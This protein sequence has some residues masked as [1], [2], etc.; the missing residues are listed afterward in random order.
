MGSLQSLTT[1][2]ERTSLLGARAP[3]LTSL[4]AA[5]PLIPRLLA[6][7]PVAEG[8]PLAIPRA[9]L[10]HA[11]EYR[12][13]RFRHCR[14]LPLSLLSYAAFIATLL[15][16]AKVSIAYDLQAAAAAAFVA[17]SGFSEL[18]ASAAGWYGWVAQGFL[19]LLLPAALNG[20]AGSDWAARPL[21]GYTVLVG[22]ARL[23]QARSVAVECTEDAGLRALYSTP[24]YPSTQLS[25]APFGAPLLGANVSAAFAPGPGRGAEGL[26]RIPYAFELIL[27]AQNTSL[28]KGVGIIEEL[29][30]GGWLDAAT[31][32]V[33]A[34]AVLYNGQIATWATVRCTMDVQRGGRLS[35]S[36]KVDVFPAD[37]Y[38]TPPDTLAEAS[39]GS[40]GSDGTDV[41]GELLVFLDLVVLLYFLYLSRGTAH[42]VW[43]VFTEKGRRAPHT[44][45]ARLPAACGY[46]LVLDYAS[47]CTLFAMGV[48]WA[49]FVARAGALRGEFAGV[50]APSPTTFSSAAFAG[51]ATR[52][53][54][55]QEAW[56]NFKVAATLALICL[57][58]RLFKYFKFQPRLAVMTDSLSMA[59]TDGAHFAFLFAVMLGAWRCK[60]HPPPPFQNPLTPPPPLP[61]PPQCATARGAASCL[62]TRPWTG[63]TR[64]SAS[65]RCSAT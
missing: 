24:C 8:A 32:S 63:P 5:P 6:S 58:L 11:L 37:P 2:S 25:S 41:P 9:L 17:G 42:R 29:R 21:N 44:C 22:G 40:G 15:L 39:D 31:R 30:A 14:S 34:T 35:Y 53:M 38:S 7:A 54:E 64:G 48:T 16:H 3:L 55:C 65:W 57:S 62:G 49:L 51:A 20:G 43:I 56:D 12:E 45:A 28:A 46:W 23:A 1:S 13:H 61:A 52:A 33:V 27:D 59:C 19:P 26:A 36:S 10:L 50:A 18:G 4:P 47:L 60:G